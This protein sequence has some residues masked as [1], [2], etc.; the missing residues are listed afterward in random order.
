MASVIGVIADTHGLV[1]AEALEALSPAGTDWF[2]RKRS[3]LSAR[4]A[5]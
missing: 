1:R 5:I 4:Q 2:E 3:K